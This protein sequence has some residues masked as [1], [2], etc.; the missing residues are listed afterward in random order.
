MMNMLLSSRHKKI[1]NLILDTK[2]PITINHIASHIDVSR[3][4]VLREMPTIYKWFEQNHYPLQ[5][6]PKSGIAFLGSKEARMHLEHILSLETT[7][8]FYT[9]KERKIYIET[10]LLQSDK[11]LKL[12]HFSSKLM[13]SEATISKDLDG[14][15]SWLSTYNLS[16]NRKQG[17]GIEILGEEKDKRRALITLIHDTL[18]GEQ[19][20]D[21]INQYIY[22]KKSKQ[23]IDIKE[24]LL[25]LIDQESIEVIENAI[26]ISEKSLNFK[27]SDRS[28]TA[29]A[30]HLAL[31]IQRIRKGEHITIQN[32]V[33]NFVTQYE[34]FYIAKTLAKQLENNLNIDISDNEVC[35]ITLHMKG[36]RFKSGLTNDQLVNFNDMIIDNFKLTVLIKRM[37]KYVSNQTK[38]QL[39]DDNR[40]LIGL[41]D[42][43]R[44]AI[45]R[46]QMHLDIRNPL[47]EKIQVTY[48]DI[49]QL[50]Q[51]AS[52]IIEEVL[53]VTMPD[54]EIGY[55]AMHF[56]SAIQRYHNNHKLKQRN[57]K[58]VVTCTSGIGTSRMLS[59]RLKSEFS[60]IDI[61]AV[62]STID[63]KES[64][65][66]ENNIDFIISSV[67]YESEYVEVISV[68]P[69]LLSD[70]I[71]KI[72]YQF[73]HFTTLTKNE[74][75]K[76]NNTKK[77]IMMINEYSNA[78]IEI[79][80]G[81]MTYQTHASS[82]DEL[83]DEYIEETAL[84]GKI[85][86]DIL[87][88]ETHGSV[89]F[90]DEHLIFLHVKSSDLS[91]LKLNVLQNH[92][93]FNYNQKQIKTAIVMLAPMHASREQLDVLGM[94][95]AQL[96]ASDDLLD[97]ITQNNHEKIYQT[98]EQI[99]KAFMIEKNNMF[100]N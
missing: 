33:F 97:I 78:I 81:Y 79:L 90:E 56:G 39:T 52:K 59:E 5:H 51:E 66:I 62:F 45:N 68:N 17:Y 86:M 24:K 11:P 15:S 75:N 29:L 25:E 49:Y 1:I 6:E 31:A 69:L 77:S 14:V 72:T 50:S 32:D 41:V 27:F 7:G 42:H 44:P 12:F 94:I 18:N 92:Q 26:R 8:V 13:V 4:T 70:D 55:I 20:K 19:I 47:L 98:L 74:Q 58:I 80:N 22:E 63:I 36:A 91:G 40:L 21:V 60:N 43:L 64:W 88:R 82:L 84:S 99:L 83:L 100:L 16:L 10:E 37:I 54:S 23:T 57:F 48:P 89:I 9:P 93:V 85:K 71:E 28:Y 76:L 3:R 65:L 73:D 53:G 87:K 2:H 96:V 46:L 34:E 67:H 30:V 61:I 38:L 95:S 35:Y